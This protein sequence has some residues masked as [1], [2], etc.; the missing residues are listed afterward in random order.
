VEWENVLF[1]DKIR[2]KTQV[3]DITVQI[4][5]RRGER[6]RDEC[7]VETNRYSVQSEM[8]WTGISMHTQP[9]PVLVRG[10]LNVRHYLGG[11]VVL[12]LFPI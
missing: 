10:N 8:R 5:R 7:V 9:Q 4:Y 11:H 2:M 1:V 3:A 6:Y 12:S